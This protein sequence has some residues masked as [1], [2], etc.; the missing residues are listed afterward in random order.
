[1]KSPAD[2]V[3]ILLVVLVPGIAFAQQGSV[4]ESGPGG[5][6]SPMMKQTNNT[7]GWNLMNAEEQRA[8]QE[9]MSTMT[10]YAECKQYIEQ[11]DKELANR[12]RA[13]GMELR[14]PDERSCDQM[15][16]MGRLQ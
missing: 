5:A 8:H 16:M 3:I 6:S 11:H 10:T 13:N 2:L 15:K 9:K 7:S 12:A 14:S 4:G 1:M